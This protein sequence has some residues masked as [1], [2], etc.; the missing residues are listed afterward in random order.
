MTVPHPNRPSL[1]Q[2][3]QFGVMFVRRLAGLAPK[4]PIADPDQRA[5]L[6][7]I[8]EANPDPDWFAG[9]WC[10]NCGA[11]HTAKYC[12]D[13]GQG[14]AQRFDLLAIGAEAW[15]SYRVF[16]MSLVQ[17]V[18]SALRSPGRVA[19][20]FVLGARKRHL[21]PLK[22]LLIAI[23]GLLLVLAQ[24]T[25]L[26]SRDA[27]LSQAMALVRTYGNWSFS[28]G[29]IAIV[30][31]TQLIWRWR[32]PFNLTEHLI[33]GVYLHA[34]II[35]VSVLNL[36]PTLIWRDPAFL[37]AHKAAATW[38]MDAIEALIL[39]VGCRQFFRLQWRRDALWLLLAASV[40]VLVKAGLLRLYAMAVVKLV[41]HQLAPA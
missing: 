2:R 8:A 30:L 32:Q 12:A 37:Q 4:A 3:A 23:A 33:L 16:E 39:M 10:Q 7:S 24:S 21:H 26:D 11:L 31:A 18:V 1:S 15:Q 20:E 27:G 40:F 29:I 6:E 25:Y 35:A 38:Y 36:L 14:K 28:I 13:C 9:D 17:G 19:R 41:L 22:V 34:S 5:R